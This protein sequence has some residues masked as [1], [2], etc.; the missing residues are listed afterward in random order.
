MKFTNVLIT[1]T[2]FV[3]NISAVA[4]PTTDDAA[5]DIRSQL[6]SQYTERTADDEELWKRKGGGGGGGRGGGSSS[7]G[8]GKGGSGGSSSGGGVRPSYG[9]GTYYGGGATTPYRS[10]G[11]SP[12]GIVPFL[13]A[14]SAFGFLG[15]AYLA[16]AYNYPYTHPYTYHNATTNQN[17]TKPVDCVCAQ[18]QDC[19]CEDNADDSWFQS[20]IGDGSYQ[21]LNKSLVNVANNATDNVSTIYI[22]G[23]LPDG[24]A[25]AFDAGAGGMASLIHAAGWWPVATAAV[26]LAFI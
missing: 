24:T 18:D 1:A 20:I 7:S 26:A 8:G 10:G 12:G 5:L 21:G 2:A 23:T 6:E 17:E 25:A 22:L 16:G 3:Q 9:G 14:G 4:V 19:G 15:G 13:I 11:R